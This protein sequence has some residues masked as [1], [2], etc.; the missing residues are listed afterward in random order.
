MG[1]VVGM[2]FPLRNYLEN[3]DSSHCAFT[4]VCSCLT[5][6]RI[7]LSR[8]M[9]CTDFFNCKSTLCVCLAIWKKKHIDIKN[10]YKYK[11]IYRL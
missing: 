2:A 8:Q 4:S 6:Q 5:V 10:I 1:L 7:L 9:C 11:K 3:G